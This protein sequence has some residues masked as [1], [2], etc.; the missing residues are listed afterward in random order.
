MQANN[1][2]PAPHAAAAPVLQK[3]TIG[4]KTGL[5]T[6][7]KLHKRGAMID[8]IEIQCACGEVIIIQCEYESSGQ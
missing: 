5:P 6:N 1:F 2:F 3:V 8:A 4:P 7:I